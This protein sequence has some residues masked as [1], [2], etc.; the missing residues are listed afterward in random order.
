MNNMENLIRS[1]GDYLY[2]THL[3]T[4]EASAC[5]VSTGAELARAY[6][7]AGYTGIIVTNHFFYGNTCVDRRLPWDAWVDAFCLGYE[8]AKD[9]GDKLGL[10]VFFGWESGYRGTEFLVYGLDKVWLKA[11][12]EIRDCSVEEQY[13]L[14]HKDG[15]IVCHAHPFR[16]EAYI[17]EI[18][19]FPAHVDAV[20]GFNA[21]HTS[22]ASLHHKN[23][24]YNE[25]A[26]RYAREHNKPVLAGSD[27]HSTQ[28]IG[29][30]TVFPYRLGDIHDFCRAVL[31]REMTGWLDGQRLYTDL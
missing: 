29:G 12:P 7:A 26:L 16:E 2:E 22:P 11:H 10:Q 15:G 30:G 25:R 1:A 9:E 21:A 19:L 6:H 5:A 28:L 4:C 3:H 18:R 31:G 23:A 8:N 24:A 27:Q 13:A 17:P 20:E 14:V